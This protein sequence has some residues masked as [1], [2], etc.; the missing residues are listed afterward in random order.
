MSSGMVHNKAAANP[1]PEAKAI[2]LTPSSAL[3][4][5]SIGSKF[6]ALN[7][8]QSLKQDSSLVGT[9]SHGGLPCKEAKVM[10]FHMPEAL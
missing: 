6:L 1:D 9:L 4:Q 2:D 5:F 8:P 3:F 10:T 7:K